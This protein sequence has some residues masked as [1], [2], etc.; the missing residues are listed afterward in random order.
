MQLSL[1]WPC[2]LLWCWSPV[3]SASALS[4]GTKAGVGRKH[5]TI[6]RKDSDIQHI[7]TRIKVSSLQASNQKLIW[8]KARTTGYQLFLS[9]L[10]TSLLFPSFVY[11]SS[12]C[13]NSS[14]EMVL[15]WCFLCGRWPVPGSY[16][17]L[18]Q[19]CAAAVADF[20]NVLCDRDP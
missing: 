19:C 8:I 6:K 18:T 11:L 2:S 20:I 12:W 3:S 1:P 17:L 15:F 16:M 9:F 5:L 7:S 14:S 13:R 4:R 10:Q